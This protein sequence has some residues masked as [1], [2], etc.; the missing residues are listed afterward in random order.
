[1]SR[2]AARSRQSGSGA[3][4]GMSSIAVFGWPSL[5]RPFGA[6]FGVGGVAVL[7]V[8]IL[9]E[10]RRRG[11]QLRTRGESHDADLVWVDLPVLCVCAHQTDRLERIID[12]VGFRFVA[13]TTQTIAQDDRIDAVVE[14]IRNKIGPLGADIDCSSPGERSGDDGS[15]VIPEELAFTMTPRL[16]S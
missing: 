12:G 9:K 14:E 6:V 16:S 1:M 7:F 3:R 15:V 4:S 11:G 8:E 2:K 5:G 10:D 13:I